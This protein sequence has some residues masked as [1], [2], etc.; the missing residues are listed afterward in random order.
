MGHRI[1]V[2]SY[3][4][5]SDAI[6]ILVYS[7]TGAQNDPMNVYDYKFLLFSKVTEKY[8]KSIQT[9]KK[10]ADPY[11]WNRLDNL[12]CGEEDRTMDIGMRF[13]RVMFGLIPE[14][15]KDATAEEQ[16]VAKFK[17]LLE[18]L[19]RLREKD[20]STSTLNVKIVTSLDKSE[21]DK[22]EVFRGRRDMTDSMIRF[23][24]QLVRGKKDTFEWV[25][26]AIN[27]TFDTS[28]SYRI[29]FNWLVASSAKVENQLNL[30]QRRCTQFGLKLTR[31]PQTTV[32]YSLH[33]HALAVPTFL[34][35]RD[36]KKSE[37]VGE[38]LSKLDFVYDG[39][40][41]T[42]AQFLEC[43]DDSEDFYFPTQRS[44]KIKKIAS[45]QY[46]HRSGALF[47]RKLTDRQGK[48]I[49]AGIENY[50]HASSENKFRDTAKGIIKD[51]FKAVD[52]LPGDD[53]S[54][55]V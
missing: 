4:P 45:H 40:T 35:I 3:N 26:V 9:F 20:R 29:M 1:Q 32:S 14:S 16:Y 8:T 17:K 2:L 24:V 54:G 52:E 28:K 21:N 7:R 11:T 5:V 42:D 10:Y 47:I 27:E 37:A 31:F 39:V 48:V 53:S 49:L 12:I 18:Y 43:I 15:F 19:E 33:L 44:G 25:E 23:S 51:L 22:D 55:E 41:L 50:R 36:K 46:V 38:A 34:C 13:R 6:D 30:L